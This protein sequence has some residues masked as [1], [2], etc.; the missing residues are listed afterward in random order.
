MSFDQSINHKK[1]EVVEEKVEE[2]VE[3]PVVEAVVA[4]ESEKKFDATDVNED[5]KTDLKDAVE[6]VKKVVK[7]SRFRK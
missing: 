2:V 5:G 6:V 4:S 1:V 7:K 3:I